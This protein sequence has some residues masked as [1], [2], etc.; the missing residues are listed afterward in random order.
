MNLPDY[1]TYIFKEINAPLP[2]KIKY[3]LEKFVKIPVLL[4][5]KTFKT[6][7]PL[8]YLFK[9]DYILQNNLGKWKIK[10]HSDYDYSINPMHEEGLA[11][12]FKSCRGVFLDIGAHIGKWSIVAGKTAQKAYA[13]EPT[14]EPYTY[15]TQNIALNAMSDKVVA[16][17]KGVSSAKGEMTFEISATNS[18]MSKIVS[19][20]TKS[21]QTLTI[22]T[23]SIDE[24][25]KENNVATGE[26]DLIKID[27]EGHEL[28]V[29]KGM[30]NLLAENKRMRIV[31]EI[32]HDQTE[33]PQ[34]LEY[35]KKFGFKS[36]QLPSKTDYFFEKE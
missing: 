19:D 17:N 12:I 23:I 31:C 15:L 20:S 35:M 33:K 1:L 32:L 36:R 25:L 5:N 29:L 2:F 24:F 30:K 14:P 34:I 4:I 13:F 26:I 18:S 11:E 8:P 3:A 16:V 7:L 9:E 28:E 21:A 27:V 22:P 10:S 6:K